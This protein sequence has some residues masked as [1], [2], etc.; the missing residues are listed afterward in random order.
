MPESLD[1]QWLCQAPLADDEDDDEGMPDAEDVFG[2]RG[3]KPVLNAH[4]VRKQAAEMQRV[5]DTI[6]R[7]DSNSDPDQDV[8]S[9]PGSPS[10][11]PRTKVEIRKR[12]A[13]SAAPPAAKGGAQSFGGLEVRF[14]RLV[15]KA[16]EADPPSCFT[17]SLTHVLQQERNRLRL[18]RR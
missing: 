13:K 10:S 5:R 8:F 11:S 16:I 7:D 6:H 2:P 3:A 1:S 4:D 14:D 17:V 12:V 15:A 18:Y 9:P